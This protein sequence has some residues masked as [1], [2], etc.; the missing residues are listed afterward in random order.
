MWYYVF[1]MKDTFI[2]VLPPMIEG[3]E[4]RIVPLTERL[5]KGHILFLSK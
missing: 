2:F 3:N 5:L 1:Q 4:L